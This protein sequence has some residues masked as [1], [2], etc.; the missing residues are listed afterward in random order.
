VTRGSIL[1]FSAVCLLGGVGYQLLAGSDASGAGPSGMLVA[2][3]AA[4]AI[5]CGIVAWLG[6]VVLA[7]RAGSMVWLVVAALPL[8]PINS[9]VC[10]MFCPKSPPERRR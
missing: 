10:A 4:A 2:L 3:L 8:F 9:M 5:V 7:L 1:S 6:G